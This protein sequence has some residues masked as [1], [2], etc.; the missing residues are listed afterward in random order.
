MEILMSM[1]QP[2]AASFER[3]A[4]AR[5]H[6][7]YVTHDPPDTPLG[8][9]GGT[10][11]LLS[12]AWRDSGHDNFS[13]WLHDQPK[14]ITH[15]G[16]QSRRLP[17]YAPIGKALMPIPVFRWAYGQRLDQTLIDLQLPDYRRLFSAAPQ[18]YTMM[19]TSGDVMI[20]F[21]HKLPPLP[22]VDILCLGLWVAPEEAQHF[23]VFFC[24]R[25][26]P[27]QLEFFLQK[28]EAARV[29][30]LAAHYLFLVDTGIWL[31][32][33]RAV[34]VLMQK[35]GWDEDAQHFSNG[36]P[37]EYELYAGFGLGLGR[38]PTESDPEIN[39]LTAA[40]VP[41]PDGEFYHFGTSRDL[42][43]SVTR[44]QRRVLDQNKL[45]LVTIEARLNQHTQNARID[46]ALQPS[47]RPLWIENAVLPES[48]QLLREHVLTGIPANDW[49]ISVPPGICIDAVPLTDGRTGWRVYGIDDVF[50]GPISG[51]DTTF[52]GRPLSQWLAAREL[53]P[54]DLGADELDIQLAPLFPAVAESEMD[55]ALLTWLWADTPDPGGR[56]RWLQATRLSARQLA[57]QVDLDAV[58]ARRRQNL[59]NTVEPM[60]R[61]HATSVFHMLDLDATAELFGDREFPPELDAAAPTMKR[62]RDHMFRAQV[63]RRRGDSA[64]AAQEQTAFGVLRRAIVGAVGQPVT[65]QNTLLPDQIIWGRSPVR[66]DLAGGWTDTPPYCLQYGGSVL[67]LAVNLNGQPPIQVFARV[68]ERPEIVLRSIDLGVE[69]RLA[70]YEQVADYANVGSGFTIGRAALALAGFHPSF[71]QQKYT[72]LEKQ[73]KAFGGGIELSLVAA[74][75][76]GSGLGTSSILAATILGVLSELCG[77]DW[78]EVEIIRR[79]LALE[80]MLTTGGGWQ[81][82]VGGILR[83][84]KLTRTQPGLDQL[85]AVRFLPEHV[86]GPENLNRSIL[87]Y[88]TGLTRVAKDILQ[89]IVRGMFLNAGPRLRVLEEIAANAAAG[90]QAIAH[91][92]LQA[93]Q[94]CV[95]RSWQLNQQLDQGTCPPPVQSL[96]DGIRDYAGGL[97]LLGAGGGGYMV[98][99]AKDLQAAEHICQ[100]L[101]THPPSSGARLVQMDVSSTGLEITRS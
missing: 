61:H 34:R 23:G 82:Q 17:A 65:P 69:E 98:I 42:I 60:M 38:T 85:P 33:E 92:D 101:L 79:T 39:G 4:P 90:E 58:F 91:H 55:E 3:H 28:P 16:G 62:V 14:L 36:I 93:L 54:S 30:E 49:Q 32:S 56:D 63:L 41:L 44:L 46:A 7:W 15:S 13:G 10:A 6:D 68:S 95:A 51:A 73:L 25:R 31:F 5:M 20:K 40:V 26:E 50:R 52:A 53:T 19:L 97:K 1:P 37:D 66:L 100:Y 11:W 21:A 29:R 59:E 94:A 83:G 84:V 88:Y 57:E 80:Q 71:C 24:P 43:E 87:L 81:D 76:K 22:A 8:S 77:L 45:G 78:D 27:D 35:C 96:A 74:V 64:A 9:G 48:W 89:E 75:P 67:N 2:M 12:R 72:S 99:F 18:P 86:L 47:C 70:T